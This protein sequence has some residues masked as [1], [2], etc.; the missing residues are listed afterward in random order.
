MKIIN[1]NKSKLTKENIFKFLKDAT[2]KGLIINLLCLMI[3]I[4]VIFLVPNIWL[5]LGIYYICWFIIIRFYDKVVNFLFR[6]I[7]K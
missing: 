1:F 2:N 4:V 5:K 7:C 6:D 3:L